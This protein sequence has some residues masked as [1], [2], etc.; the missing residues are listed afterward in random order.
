MKNSNIVMT[1]PRTA[2]ERTPLIESGQSENGSVAIEYGN[3]ESSSQ[4]GSPKEGRF[5]SIR[6]LS[7]RMSALVQQHTGMLHDTPL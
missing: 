2:D 4:E 5:S 6:G 1:P 3:G 7:Q